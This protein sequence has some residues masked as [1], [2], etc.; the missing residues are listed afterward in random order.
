MHNLSVSGSKVPTISDKTRDTSIFVR[1]RSIFHFHYCF[2]PKPQTMI[3]G[4]SQAP[5]FMVIMI[6]LW[7]L[8]FGAKSDGFWDYIL[9]NL[10]HGQSPK[11]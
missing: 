11:S 1:F 4:G 3:L 8:I 10:D 2:L 9:G 7:Q 5:G 6:W